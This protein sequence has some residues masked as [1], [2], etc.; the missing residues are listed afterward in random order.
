MADALAMIANLKISL[1]W[2][3][4]VSMVPTDTK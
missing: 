4:I 2:Q 1:G 3:R